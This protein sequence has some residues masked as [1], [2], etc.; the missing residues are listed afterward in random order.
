MEVVAAEET[1]TDG[2]VEPA[3][4]GM[5]DGAGFNSTSVPRSEAGQCGG[6]SEEESLAPAAIGTIEG[7]G[8]TVEGTEGS[9]SVTEGSSEGMSAGPKISATEPEPEPKRERLDTALAALASA[10]A[11]E[12]TWEGLNIKCGELPAIRAAAEKLGVKPLFVAAVAISGVLAFILYGVGGQLICTA[13]GFLYP[14]FESFKAVESGD[15]VAMQLWLM[16]WVVWAIFLSIEHICY[17]VLIWIPFYYPIK[18]GT[19]LWLFNP[20]TRGAKYV[21]YWLVLPFLYRN[22]ERIDSALDTLK[23]SMSGTLS[24]A[25]GLSVSSAVAV[26]TGSFVQL[27]RRFVAVLLD[28]KSVKKAK[29]KAAEHDAD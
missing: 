24:S 21:Y 29:A 25:I 17:Y 28:T 5:K 23:T 10:L 19:L 12:K 8:G 9:T 15:P 20:T 26:G 27:R 22:R 2:R 13:L 3:V 11:N 6:V 4:E 18:L 14:A 1:C 7:S 16:Y